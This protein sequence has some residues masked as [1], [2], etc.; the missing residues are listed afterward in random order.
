[1]IQ[2]TSIIPSTDLSGVYRADLCHQGLLR[3]AEEG[4]A[5]DGSDG[6]RVELTHGLPR[7]P[8]VGATGR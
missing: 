7:Q 5:L 8:G 6:L 2:S 1:M 3:L 4:L